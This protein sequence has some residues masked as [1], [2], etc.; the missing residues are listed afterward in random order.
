LRTTTKRR[1]AKRGYALVSTLIAIFCLL[2]A[3]SSL[4]ATAD[5]AARLANRRT[6][7]AQ[8]LNLATS[9]ADI[10]K[11]GAKASTTYTGFGA[12]TLGGGALSATV[13]PVSGQ[14]DQREITGTGTVA[15]RQGA[16]TRKVRI[17]VNTVD[18]PPA[19]RY[20]LVVEKD[21]SMNGSIG[22]SPSVLASPVSVHTN[23]SASL[24]GSGISVTGKLSAVGAVAQSGSPRVSG[25]ITTGAQPVPFPP[26]DSSLKDRAQKDG[27][28]S[29]NVSVSNGSLISGVIQ[30]S[31][32]IGSPSGCRIDGIVWV[33]GSLSVS[34]PV[35]GKGTL[36]CEG[37]MALSASL[38][39]PSSGNVLFITTSNSDNAVTLSGNSVF[40]GVVYAPNGG[41]R[42]NGGP[43]LVGSI[44]SK[45]VSFSGSLNI[46]GW[47]GYY[48][49]PPP[50]PGAF[51]V[52]GWQAL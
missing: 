5:T 18:F 20:A 52:L 13:L 17:T 45:T 3:A 16:V 36:I 29:G 44:A 38:S 43:T 31:L 6:A 8:A 26:V 48:Q 40:K 32:T 42:T 35:T 46:V 1:R 2:I 22:I 30:G 51:R 15:T 4:Y 11:E 37:S 28:T 50:A 23:G 21:L 9:A 12:R 24:S 25:G 27:M 39:T 14:P 41:V 34:G 49:S 47:D 33:T 7:N 19:L 10:A